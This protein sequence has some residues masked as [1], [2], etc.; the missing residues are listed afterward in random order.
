M[1]QQKTKP[2]RYYETPL[3][4]GAVDKGQVILRDG[5]TAILRPVRA[6]DKSL[7]TAFVTR[8]SHDSLH[9]RFFGETSL[10]I[11]VEQLLKSSASHC[12]LIVL[13]GS[14]DASKVIAHGEYSC[15]T[16]EVEAEVAFLVDDAHQGKGLGTLLL[17]RLA[18]LANL[19]GINK[20]FG[21]TAAANL[22][23]RDVFKDSGFPVHESRDGAYV[24]ISFDISASAESVGKY[25]FREQLA[26]EASLKAFFK[27]RSVAVIGA[28]RK[29]D[30]IGGRILENMVKDGF[31]GQIYPVNP[32]AD[33]LQNLK[34]YPNLTAV[35]DDVDLA[36]IATPAPSISA[37]VDECGEKGVKALIVISAGFAETGA[38]GRALQDEVLSKARGYG[39]RIV[40]PN[41][42]G[43]LTTTPDIR[44]NASFSTNFPPHGPI[45]MSSQSGAL[46]LAVLELA[47]DMGLGMSSFVSLG[48]KA[49]VSSNDLLQY[50]EA[51]PE[52]KVILL[53]LESFGN[54]RR[55][56]RLARRVSRSKPIIAIKAGRSQEGS[57]AA[58]S[59]T[60]A[61][62]ASE[63]GVEALFEQAGIIRA[64][65]LEEMFEYSSLFAEQSLPEGPKVAVVTNAGGPGILATDALISG[66]LQVPEL[67]ESVKEN[68]ASFL[69]AAA[70][71][72]NP[73]DMIA[74]ASAT[75]FRKTTET[76]LFDDSTDAVLVILT[77]VGL[78][79]TED[80]A[81]AIRDAVIT[82]REQ[83]VTK[84]VLACIMDS[85]KVTAELKLKDERIPNFRFPES[86]ARAL[87]KAYAYAQWR[88]EPVGQQFAY[89]DIDTAKAR[90]ILAKT[91]ERGG[92]WLLADEVDDVLKAYGLPVA[93]GKLAHSSIEAVAYAKEMNG[94]V[95]LKLASK[96]L[97]HK[98]EWDGVQ[99][100]LTTPEE[101]QE[102]CNT[103]SKK[104]QDAN[105][106][107]ELDGY[108]IQPMIEGGVELMLGM[109]HDP[110]FGPL[111][112]FGL[113]GIYVEILRDVVFRITPL[114]DLD[115]EEMITGIRGYKLLQGYRGA[116]PADIPATQDLL[117]RLS[118]MVED[119]PEIVELDFN[120]IKALEPGKGCVV[121][122]AR[123]RCEA[124]G[125]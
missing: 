45:A 15:K 71:F 14:G 8:L 79:T 35:P 23:M 115:A 86:A 111:I 96:T 3:P 10:E 53:Y 121:L 116:P 29:P 58:S 125:S 85:K 70:S 63:T 83:G 30:S 104:L 48:N 81:S 31:T 57:K 54:P 74:S 43:F 72:T 16:G 51:D 98:S 89:D 39:M 120:P 20:F 24:D 4:Q 102:A 91:Q 56:A 13:T 109:T 61:L 67:P 27:P 69:P 64:Q 84:P 5:S 73:V 50:W 32:K 110:L 42:L 88:N 9:Q 76:V 123:I 66:G 49:D 26:T 6:E 101:V 40:G 103:I 28:S 19:Q 18:V 38:E 77:P 94:P 2:Q 99:L 100:N 105:R 107:A 59:H 118:R 11:A 22:R 78:A 55:F 90:A 1:N 12:A 65:T 108:Y 47:E 92:G 60:A 21:P 33:V 25:E 113:G 124:K 37:V 75:Q 62:A 97:V 87:A 68:L 44:L 119:L 82:A 41:C 114:T 34:V 106:L 7:L 52:T 17:E 95:A 117:L 46:G 93:L 122:D 80:V 36:V 112:A